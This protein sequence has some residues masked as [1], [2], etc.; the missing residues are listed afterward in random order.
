M[1]ELKGIASHVLL[2]VRLLS[3][4]ET[5]KSYH[6]TT[7]LFPSFC[8][9]GFVLF[10]P[11]KPTTVPEFTIANGTVK[12]TKPSVTEKSVQE[13]RERLMKGGGRHNY[14][15]ATDSFSDIHPC[16]VPAARRHPARRPKRWW[17]GGR[18][19]LC[20]TSPQFCMSTI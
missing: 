1:Y 15:L 9:P 12:Y 17:G 5:M 8:P 2:W 6:F 18:H 7:P 13:E 19:W 10:P 11:V 16:S 14:W 3:S 20:S 4:L